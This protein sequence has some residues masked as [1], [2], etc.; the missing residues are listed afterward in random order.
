M[1]HNQNSDANF[2]SAMIPWL[3]SELAALRMIL[4][5]RRIRWLIRHKY[6]PD[7]PHVPAGNPDGGQ[8]T[9]VGGGSAS[10]ERHRQPSRQEI[11]DTSE[12]ARWSD[13]ADTFAPTGDL[14]AQVIADRNGTVTTTEWD[15]FGVEDWAVRQTLQ[16]A[17]G[18]TVTTTQFKRDGSGEIAFSRGAEGKFEIVNDD[19][20]LR[21]GTGGDGEGT[22]T[23]IVPEPGSRLALL[24]PSVSVITEAGAPTVT[25]LGTGAALVVIGAT[26]VPSTAGGDSTE[27]LGPDLRLNQRDDGRAPR[28]EHRV[29]DQWVPIEG[30]T[31]LAGGGETIIVD[32]QRLRA[33]IGPDDTTRAIDALAERASLT[34]VGESWE[35]D[36]G[37]QVG[38][39]LR[40]IEQSCRMY[41]DYKAAVEW[42]ASA[43][44]RD[45]LT[46]SQYGTA[47]HVAVDHY[48]KRNYPEF[49]PVTGAFNTEF[50]VRKGT[51][52]AY[53]GEKGSKRFDAYEDVGDGTVCGYDIKVG[54]RGL[55]ALR[56]AE[57]RSAARN[58]YSVRNSRQPR[59][60]IILEVRPWR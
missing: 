37:R 27:S 19:G 49:D 41:P 48:F 25:P 35:P 17:D 3:K 40:D 55:S 46:P 50:S 38:L 15:S 33:A 34:I 47:V 42:A 24:A 52:S 1:H 11:D 18:E 43:V 5:A 30:A 60:V 2:R 16:N 28:I 12:A 9:R 59:R 39:K 31:S 22:P 54:S 58:Y 23:G 10:S 51:T 13:V 6:S 44:D 8:W 53:Y 7:Q 20:D 57:L 45:G 21:L 56:I 32:A 14:Q 36:K 4:A 26:A 29:D